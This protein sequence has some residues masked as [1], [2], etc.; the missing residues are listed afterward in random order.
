MRSLFFE[1]EG[2]YPAYDKVK[3]IVDAM[4]DS[5]VIVIDSPYRCMG[6]IGELKTMLDHMGYLCMAHRPEPRLFSKSAVV[7][8]TT[9]GRDSKNVCKDISE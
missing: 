7:V 5:D 4:L 8:S 3:P 9:S 1:G 2:K 6:M